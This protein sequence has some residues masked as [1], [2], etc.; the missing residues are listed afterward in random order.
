VNSRVVRAVELLR[1]EPDAAAVK[2]ELP[3]DRV[4]YVYSSTKA[5]QVVSLT[6]DVSVAGRFAHVRLKAGTVE[7]MVLVAGSLLRVGPI[8]IACAT[9]EWTGTVDDY[10]RAGGASNCLHT[11]TR[12]PAGGAL[13]G[14]ELHLA[15][16][17]VRNAS[18]T[19]RE[20]RR[21]GAQTIIDLGHHLRPWVQGRHRPQG[22][23]ALRFR[24]GLHVLP[25]QPRAG[26]PLCR[27]HLPGRVHRAGRPRA[28][29]ATVAALLAAGIPFLFEYA[30]RTPQLVGH[31]PPSPAPS[32]LKH[33]A[34]AS[35]RFRARLELAHALPRPHDS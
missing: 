13:R 17:R 22:R 27:R 8:T 30:S 20:V 1:V 5:Q 23:R 3:D 7:S 29:V 24:A 2:V 14:Q 15:N 11:A 10:D 9:P 4:D 34:A 35:T 32:K 19:I 6:D 25:P 33:P 31:C 28:A 12:L 18:Y 21:K 26:Q 16:D